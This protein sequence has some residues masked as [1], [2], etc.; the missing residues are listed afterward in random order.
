MNQLKKKYKYSEFLKVES[1]GTPR[2]ILAESRCTSALIA[3]R[4]YYTYHDE[5]VWEHT[6]GYE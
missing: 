3:D 4:S 5:K 6:W 1:R 2:Y